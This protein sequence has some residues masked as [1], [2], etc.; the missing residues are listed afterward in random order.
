ML[1]SFIERVCISVIVIVFIDIV[2][3]SNVM[4]V[5][6]I[7]DFYYLNPLPE[8]LFR[9]RV[10]S[11]SDWVPEPDPNPKSATHNISTTYF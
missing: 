8:I 6:C 11:G 7:V 10:I 5:A 4:Y 1:A 3:I 9:V 2:G